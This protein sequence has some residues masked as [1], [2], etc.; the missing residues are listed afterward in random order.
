MTCPLGSDFFPG[1]I[2]GS[3]M[4]LLL[5]ACVARLARFSR[6][7]GHP[8]GGNVPAP[9]VC[10]YEQVPMAAARVYPL[11]RQLSHWRPTPRRYSKESSP[12]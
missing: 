4:A 12:A 8:P 5:V 2:M 11:D 1:L 6:W 3:V 7:R 9:V 10:Y